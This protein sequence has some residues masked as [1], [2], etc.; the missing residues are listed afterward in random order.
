MKKESKPEFKHSFYPDSADESKEE[1]SWQVSYLD[2]LTILLAFLIILLSVS[3]FTDDEPSSVSALFASSPEETPFITTPI[4]QVQKELEQ[5]LDRQIDAGYITVIRDLNDLRIR[6]SSDDLYRSGSAT[7]QQQA[8]PLFDDVLE[9]IQSNRYNDFDIEVEGHTD[10]TPITSGAYPSNWELSTARA[11][12]V[13]KYFKGMGIETNRL[14]ASGFADSKPLVP[15]DDRY[16]LPIYK[17]KAVNRRVDIRLYYSGKPPADSS[18]Q[19]FD[20]KQLNNTCK[21]GVQIA[22]FNSLN[23]GLS[24]VDKSEKETTLPFQ[25]YNRNTAFAVRSSSFYSITAA[26]NTL[27]F[28]S[29]FFPEH[30][31]G[32]V[33]SCGDNHAPAFTATRYQIQLAAFQKQENAEQYQNSMQTRHGLNLVLTQQASGAYRV[34]TEPL[35]NIEDARRK[36][37]SLKEKGF[38]ESIFIQAYIPNTSTDSAVFHIQVGVFENRDLASV[39]SAEMDVNFSLNTKIYEFEKGR[40]YLLTEQLSNWQEV[41]ALYARLSQNTSGFTPVIYWRE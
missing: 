18:A 8:L 30:V 28:I 19:F 32:L 34:L 6:F 23:A 16:G 10:N 1:N 4:K 9:A 39:K 5:A 15:N 29:R 12:N 35:E 13:V 37:K 2:I 7:L 20:F 38:S 26:K 31:A 24:A 41:Q 3:K 40:F 36:L 11:V 33:L 27:S 17:N 14:K 21:F 25:V 22:G